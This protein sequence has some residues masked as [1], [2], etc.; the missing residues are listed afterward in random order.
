MA[1]SAVST[2]SAAANKWLSQMQGGT[3]Q[4]NYTNGINACNV[5][6]MALAATPEA[7]AKYQQATAMAVS[8]GKM[9]TALN[10]APV[11]SWKQGAITKGAANL[12]TGARN[13]QAKVQAAMAKLAPSWQAMSAA[14]KAVQ[15]PKGYATGMAKFQA[16]M[17]AQAQ[18]LG[19]TV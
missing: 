12:S 10:N 18:A 15:G 9:A 2:A 3:A 8:S 7:Q 16:A 13:A 11:G 14:A 6:P 19:K 4:Q 17:Q 1:K 5:N